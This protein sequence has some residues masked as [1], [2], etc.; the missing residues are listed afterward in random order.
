VKLQRHS[1]TPLPAPS[2]TTNRVSFKDL[3]RGQEVSGAWA[4][5]S[6]AMLARFFRDRVMPDSDISVKGKGPEVW[7]TL[8]ALYILME[9]F[10]DRESEWTNIA[11]KAKGYLSGQGV[12]AN[13]ILNKL[14]LD[15]A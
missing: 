10:P 5:S 7:S 3:L 13:R 8:L 15:L 12:N 14:N 9:E 11:F 6:S 2:P 4:V 1:P